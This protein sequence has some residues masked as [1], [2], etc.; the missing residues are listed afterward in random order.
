PDIAR[1][2]AVAREVFAM[3]SFWRE[4]EA[5]DNEVAA[6][7]QTDMLLVARRLIE[8]A[9]RWL[10]RNRRRPLDIAATIADFAA[11][12]RELA[13]HL[14]E[15]LVDGDHEEWA[16]RVATLDAAGVPRAL[17]ERTAGLDALLAAFDIV[18]V[19]GASG[20]TIR[21][22]A[23]LHFRV[24]ARL[25]L[26]WLR[27]RIGTLP[28]DDC[29]QTMARAALR[30]DLLGLHREL[31]DDVLRESPRQGTVDERLDA[32]MAGN[33]AM[34][35][36]SLGIIDDIRAGGSY[37]LTTLPVALREIRA[38]IHDTSPVGE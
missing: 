4:V 24:G 36:R 37:D 28:R 9:T 35:D 25:R 8:R 5:L 29:W 20:R 13:E 26:H 18:E 15:I 10:L 6:A 19:A 17:A 30:D 21:E 14:P 32:W 16:Q 31:T 7:T 33:Q 34:L 12:A 38:L 1:A 2:Y 23:E 11:G 27:D 22:V 3:P